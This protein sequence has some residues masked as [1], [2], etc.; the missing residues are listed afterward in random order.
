MEHPNIIDSTKDFPAKQTQDYP[1]IKISK[2]PSDSQL[3]YKIKVLIVIVLSL[4]F[5]YLNQLEINSSS[6]DADKNLIAIILSTITLFP[7]IAF[8]LITPL[9]NA[10]IKMG[11]ILIISN[12]K[13][14]KVQQLYSKVYLNTPTSLILW[15]TMFFIIKAG[16][17]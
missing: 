17:N 16:M 3:V 4:V 9:L 6:L 1:Q 12:I 14:I 7:L 11:H 5:I 15:Y 10:I 2:P 13:N 8:F